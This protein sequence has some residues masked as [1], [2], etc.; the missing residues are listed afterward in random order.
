MN[1]VLL[2]L[3]TAISGQ[4]SAPFFFRKPLAHGALCEA[5]PTAT[6]PWALA[7]WGPQDHKLV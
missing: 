6:R 2:V 5:D 3:I 4:N 7:V 1:G